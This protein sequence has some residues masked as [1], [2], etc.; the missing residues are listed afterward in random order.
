MQPVTVEGA[1]Q[2]AGLYTDEYLADLN[3]VLRGRYITPRGA[4]CIGVVESI[5]RNTLQKMPTLYL[6]QVAA[7][8]NSVEE[9]ISVAQRWIE[10]E[11]AGQG[12]KP[13]GAK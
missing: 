8:C 6:L 5:V 9:A 4:Y 11:I 1:W 10:E 7:D 2:A 13:R 12:H 3:T